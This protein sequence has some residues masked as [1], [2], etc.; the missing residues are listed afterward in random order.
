MSCVI[1]DRIQMIKEGKNPYFICEL[2]TGYVVFGDNQ[3]F[4]GYT[5]LNYIN[6]L[7]ILR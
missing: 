7:M 2:E 3:R 5:L 6:Y 4:K 1:C